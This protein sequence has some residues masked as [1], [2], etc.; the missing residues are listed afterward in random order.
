[1]VD[2][3]LKILP[4]V[5]NETSGNKTNENRSSELY[6]PLPSIPKNFINI[7]A[8][9]DIRCSL[10]LHYNIFCIGK[11]HVTITW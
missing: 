4:V 11:L 10:I 2:K 6:R 1:M 8:H 3:V 7:M 5:D 9:V